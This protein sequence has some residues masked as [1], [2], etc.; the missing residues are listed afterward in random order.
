MNDYD[1][2]YIFKSTFGL[3]YRERDA[4][5]R[6]RQGGRERSPWWYRQAE[7]CWMEQLEGRESD[8]LKIRYR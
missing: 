1:A 4:D 6:R 2:T 8:L 3:L 5:G 7:S